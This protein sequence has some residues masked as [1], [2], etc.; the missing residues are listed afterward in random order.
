MV[1]YKEKEKILQ[2]RNLSNVIFQD[3]IRRVFWSNSLVAE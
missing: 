3:V 2:V 1:G